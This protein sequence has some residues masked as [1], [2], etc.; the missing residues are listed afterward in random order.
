MIIYMRHANDSEKRPHYKHDARISNSGKESTKK[1]AKEMVEKYGYP[2][3]IHF[4]P[5]MRCTETA[6]ILH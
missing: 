5:F 3:K 4:S 2:S 6:T 1:V